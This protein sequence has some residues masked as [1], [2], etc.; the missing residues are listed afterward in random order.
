MVVIV[1]I[2]ILFSIGIG[3]WLANRALS[4]ISSF[5]SAARSVRSSELSR[6]L[7][8]N[9]QTQDELTELAET[10]NEMLDRLE[11]GFER[12]KRITSD[13]AHELL[14]PLASIL[15]Q[16][17]V[18][19]RKNRETEEYRK[20]IE[21]LH[22]QADKASNMV[23]LLLQLSRVEASGSVELHDVEM[24]EV[25]LSQIEK[26]T[27]RIKQ[28][29]LHVLMERADPGSIRINQAHAEQIAFNLLHNAIKYTREWINY[30]I[31]VAP[32]KILES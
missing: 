2:C 23:Q 27:G 19:L 26:L 5:I 20:G 3:Y 30:S 1:L 8:V 13:A 11:N 9:Q 22:K 32:K 21:Q 16:T 28:K 24:S 14:T 7:P 6:R 18:L 17:E 31:M 15:N 12:E 10:F 4:P 25:I 29:K